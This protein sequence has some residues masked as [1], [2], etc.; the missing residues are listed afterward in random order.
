MTPAELAERLRARQS[1]AGWVG[2]CPAHPDRT[3]SLSFREGRDERVLPHCWAGCATSDVLTAAKLS[4]R[5]ISA[6]SENHGR[7]RRERDWQQVA[8][9]A[10]RRHRESLAAADAIAARA[11]TIVQRLAAIEFAGAAPAWPGEADAL[12]ADYHAALAAGREC[13]VAA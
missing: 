12:A 1:G 7:L 11:A 8:E 10:Q 13:E 6:S 4:W 3:P 9:A 5:D 2:R